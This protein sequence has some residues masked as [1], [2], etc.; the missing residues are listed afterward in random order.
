METYGSGNFPSNRPELHAII[1]DAI[2]RGVIVV[3]ISQCRRGEVSEVYE[4]A[5]I[6]GQLGVTH[7]LDMTRECALAKL[8][9]LLGKCGDCLMPTRATSALRGP[10]EPGAALSPVSIP[11]PAN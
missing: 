5:V 3:N 4:G 6:M 1:K 2:S 8:S 7:G 11:Q 9:Y 10:V